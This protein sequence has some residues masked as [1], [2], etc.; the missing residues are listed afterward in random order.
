MLTTGFVSLHLSQSGSPFFVYFGFLCLQVFSV[1]NFCPD[2]RGWR[3]PL[4]QAPLFSGAVGREGPCKYR[5]CVGVVLAVYG[6]H[7]VCPVH[8][9]VCFLGLHCSGFKVLCRG[10]VPSR[11]CVSCTSQVSGV[12]AQT[13]HKGTG[14]A[15]C[16]LGERTV[17]GGRC[18]L[19]T[20][21]CWLL[22]FRS[23]VRCALR[24]PAQL[25]CV[26]PLGADLRLWPSWKMPTIQ[27]PRRAWLA[28]GNLLSLVEDACLWGWDWSSP[29]PS[30]PRG[31]ACLSA[32]YGKGTARSR[33]GLLPCLLN[34]LLCERVRLPVRA[35]CGKV[36]FFFPSLV[37]PQFWLLSC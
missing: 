16:V 37:I 24:E 4:V 9:S 29:L 31:P 33:L 18:V 7:W 25:C 8:G 35:F 1:S 30:G 22:A 6:L 12:Q 5:W 11:P 14:S 34:P 32:S 23:A 17:P 13:I 21:N 10:T 28:T 19:L 2:T 20:P 3:W 26:C 27:D 15:G 36:L